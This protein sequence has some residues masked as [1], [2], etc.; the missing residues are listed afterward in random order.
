MTIEAV[1]TRNQFKGRIREIVDGAVVSEVVVE[2]DHGS[3][4]SVISTRSVRELNL[5]IG[6][7]VLTLVKA[8]DVALAKLYPL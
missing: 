1:N 7:E 8:T 6:T 3:V 2:T 4:V 5:K